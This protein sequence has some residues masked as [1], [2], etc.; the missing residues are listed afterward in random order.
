MHHISTTAAAAGD[1]CSKVKDMHNP[2]KATDAV[3]SWSV[4]RFI[5]QCGNWIVDGRLGMN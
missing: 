2:V 1:A 5:G 4:N 3:F